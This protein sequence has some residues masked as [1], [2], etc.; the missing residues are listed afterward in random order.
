[1]MI[2]DIQDD[3]DDDNQIIDNQQKI[4]WYLIDT[5]RNF[6]KAWNFLITI[7]TIYNL[8][9]T[10]FIMVFP[11]VYQI[12]NPL[13]VNPSDNYGNSTHPNPI[14]YDCES[15]DYITDGPSINSQKALMNIER[16]ID[17]IYTIEILFCFVKRTMA[18]KDIKSI[19]LN[20]LQFYFWFD[21][22]GTIPNLF[23]LQEGIRFYWLKV[24]RF[25]H[26]SR[27]NTPPKLL[28]GVLLSKY[29]KKRQN[30]LTQFAILIVLVI[31]I[32]HICACIWLWLG[33]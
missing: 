10:P 33:A 28:M 31:Y 25:I 18:H 12:C 30:D 16:V 14:N 7:L 27:L 9:V 32:S 24:F 20:Y 23:F 22:I 13:K 3:E 26:I 17:I 8:I 21:A 15:N 11:D 2:D 5:E 1:M 29:S 19:A 4:K 6:C